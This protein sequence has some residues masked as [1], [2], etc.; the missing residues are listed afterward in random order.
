MKKL[1]LIAVVL[2]MAAPLYAEREIKFT[3][4][5]GWDGTATIAW[6]VN[7]LDVAPVA[8]GLTIEVVAGNPIKEVACEDESD[9]MEIYM[10]AA[11]SEEVWRRHSDC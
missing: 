4:T 6:D 8:M 5:G 11:Y 10:D 9:F 3:L 1:M 7:D 2:M